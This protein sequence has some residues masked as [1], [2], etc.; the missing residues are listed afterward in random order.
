MIEVLITMMIIS[1]ALLGTVGLQTYSLRLNQGGQFRTQAVFLAAEL[2]ERMEANRAGSVAANYVYACPT[3]AAAVSTACTTATCT[4]SALATYDLLQWRKSVADALPTSTCSVVQATAGN[5][6]TYSITI[7][8][9]DRKTDSNYASSA[10]NASGT[11]EIL[12]YVATR[13]ILN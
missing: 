6:S 4:A 12:S 5:P 1:F 10:E 3:T 11:G 9:E 2:A 8:W 7:S 13:T